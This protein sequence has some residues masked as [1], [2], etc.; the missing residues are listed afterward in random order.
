MYYSIN[1]TAVRIIKTGD[2]QT[3]FTGSAKYTANTPDAITGKKKDR[4]RLTSDVAAPTPSN[5]STPGDAQTAASPSKRAYKLN[6][7]KIRQK[8][9]AFFNLQA[10]REFCAFYTITFPAGTGDDDAYKLFNLWQTRCRKG[11]GLK[12]FI[13]VA[14]R[15]KNGTIHYHMLTNTHMP[16]KQVVEYMRTSLRPYAG[17][18]GWNPATVDKYN[19]I[20]VDNVWYPKRRKDSGSTQRRTRNDASRYLGRYITKYV[21]KSTATFTRLAWHESH[22][23]AALFTAQNFDRG[24]IT[25]LISYFQQTKGNWRKWENEYVEIYA[26]PTVYDLNP[27]LDLARVN[28]TVYRQMHA[29]AA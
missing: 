13:W 10:T 5:T 9:N 4:R 2:A 26:H 3:T 24:E 12:S 19:G 6:K 20:D 21:T 25:D 23:V 27:W 8:I 14:E 22:D 17:K 28:E 18:Y 16:I 29:P 15:Q 1:S 7:S 11:N